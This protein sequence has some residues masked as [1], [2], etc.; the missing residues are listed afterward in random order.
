[1]T[2]QLIFTDSYNRRAARFLKRHPELQPTYR[3]VLLLLEANP[4]HPCLRLDALQR[5]LKGLHSV[6]IHLSDRI[7]IELLIDDNRIIPIAVGDHDTVYR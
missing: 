2:W 3:K 5:K 6:S 1:M 7:T 4:F